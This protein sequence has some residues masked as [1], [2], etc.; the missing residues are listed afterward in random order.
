MTSK[1]IN[2]YA[3]ENFEILKKISG[4]SDRDMSAYFGWASCATKYSKLSRNAKWSVPEL[5]QLKKLLRDVDVMDFFDKHL[6][7]QLR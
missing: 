1:D 2:K 7:Y 6:G 3:W 5:R 4:R